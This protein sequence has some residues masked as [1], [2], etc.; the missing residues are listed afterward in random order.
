MEGSLSLC[1]P[2]V[3][4][5]I[6]GGRDSVVASLCQLSEPGGELVDAVSE[7]PRSRHV[8]ALPEIVEVAAPSCLGDVVLQ[9]GEL[10]A[11][12]ARLGHLLLDVCDAIGE[13]GVGGQRGHALR[14]LG[15]HGCEILC[16]SCVS[17]GGEPFDR[18]GEPCD[19]LGARELVEPSLDPGQPLLDGAGLGTERRQVRV[20]TRREGGELLLD[21]G[22]RVLQG[23]G[24]RRAVRG[25]IRAGRSGREIVPRLDRLRVGRTQLLQAGPLLRERPGEVEPLDH[26]HPHEDL[27]ETVAGLGLDPQRLVELLLGRHPPLDEDL[28]Q[29][30]L[31]LGVDRVPILDQAHGRHREL[32]RALVASSPLHRRPLLGEH[33]RELDPRDAERGHEH[34]ADHLAG[35][36]L[37]DERL[38]E[39]LLGD[40]AT[41]DEDL[42]DQTGREDSRLA[43]WTGYRQSPVR[44]TAL[45]QHPPNEGFAG[46]VAAVEVTRIED[47]LWRW[48]TAHPSWTPDDDWGQAVGCVYWEGPSEVVLV[49][50]LVPVDDAERDRF[51]RALDRDVERLGRP[52]V[53]L[54]TCSW[55]DRSEAAVSARYGGRVVGPLDDEASLPDG[56]G[57]IHV[58]VAGETVWWLEGARA[59]VP[60]DTLLG[61]GEGGVRLCPTSWLDGGGSSAELATE[62]VPLLDLP[63]ERV[64]VSHGDPVLADGAAALRHAL[65]PRE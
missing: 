3:E 16:S 56:V 37:D 19:L 62:L 46:S 48:S 60:G 41:L 4:L 23:R 8:E 33:A 36:L 40:E 28:A 59:V 35:A 51:W 24:V 50:P 52:V 57:A 58:P 32:D 26:A 29:R 39:L 21:A 1:D 54:V 27:A 34:L 63:V 20:G 31:R 64:L 2:G 6:G 47:G 10:C 22:N 5:R 11:K 30:P 45:A 7:R 44:T 18:P 25:S 53:T 49:D 38:L 55:H 42:A 65:V 9:S 15:E 13:R 14:E 17:L 12:R 61:D 43:H